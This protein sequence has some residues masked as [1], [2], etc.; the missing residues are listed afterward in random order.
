MEAAITMFAPQIAQLAKRLPRPAFSDCVLFFFFCFSSVRDDVSIRSPTSQ[1]HY[2]YFFSDVL[3]VH[4]NAC[5]ACAM[6]HVESAEQPYSALARID[7]TASVYIV[8]KD[9]ILYSSVP[10]VQEVH[11]SAQRSA[12]SPAQSDYIFQTIAE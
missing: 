10:L 5:N 6:S 8:A 7:R 11:G 9:L 1:L 12:P 2:T 3:V 4:R